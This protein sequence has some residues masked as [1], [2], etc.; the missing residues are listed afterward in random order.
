M[1]IIL[2]I[3]LILQ[4]Y[5][6]HFTEGILKMHK[7]VSFILSVSQRFFK[8]LAILMAS[9]CFAQVVQ[10]TEPV[11]PSEYDI[12]LEEAWITMP[13][14]VRL[15]VD[16]YMPVGGSTGE[17]YPVILQYDPYRKIES[18]D[19][20][21]SN[22]SYFV[23]RGYVIARV[24]IR[25]SGNSEGHLVPY[26]YSDQE[27]DDGEVI[28]DWLSK[29]NWSNGNV[30]MFG[31]SWSGFNSIQL[32]VRNPPALKAI[33]AIDSTEDLYQDD[34]HYMDGIMHVDIWEMLQELY[35]SMP[36]APDYI[37][38][39][40]YFQNRFDAKPWMLTWKRQQRDGPFWDRASARDKYDQIRIPTFHIGGWYDGY[41]DSVPRMLENVKAPV[42]AIVGAWN[43]AW[44]HDPIQLPGI[45]WRH[46]GVRWF[47]QWL[48]GKDTGIM[49]EP[50]LAVYVREWHGPGLTL[51]YAPGHWRWEKDWPIQDVEQLKL[52]PQ[53]NH[54]LSKQKPA[55]T[56]HRLKYVATSG[57]EASGPE[58]WWG[59]LANDQRPTDAFSLTYDTEPLAQDIEILG[60]PKALLRVEADT[61]RANWFVKLSDVAPDGAVTLITG[62]GFN[63]THRKSARKP[64]DIEP[65]VS[66]PL[67]IEMHF[68]SWV[69]PKGHRIRISISNAQW[70]MM[71]PTPYPMTTGLYLGGSIG[72]QI[73]LPVIPVRNTET[74]PPFLPPTNNAPKVKGY[75]SRQIGNSPG[76]GV[77]SSIKRNPQTGEAA[78]TVTGEGVSIYP[79]GE[80]RYQERTLFETSD[81]NPD[82]TSVSG[83]HEIEVTLK[84]RV[85]LWDAD[86]SFSSD[87]KNF[88]YRYKR[89]LKENDQLLREKEWTDVI[90]RDFQ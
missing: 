54:S 78:I 6:F 18:R 58:L 40:E 16:L 36:A 71:W 14:D 20:S 19:S 85:L 59:S 42:K 69:F 65:G 89:S 56:I 26:D 88:F 70:P 51:D 28:I 8:T 23:R 5:S 2:I 67:D 30:G 12:K 22:Y 46:E 83:H 39:K 34:V 25:G 49:D 37:I 82:K 60:L 9:V 44:P 35:N 77:M 29:Q 86:F 55:E 62:A 10:A 80:Q 90:P 41:R 4:V 57:V 52:F 21:M 64:E 33:I 73:I 48:K 17:K 63:G 38:D 53:D 68:T 7:N 84:G 45:E 79:W 31:V 87:E 74:A 66:F 24:D 76:Y 43:H 72:S 75:G 13:D 15:S 32:A 50:K 47:D 27:L 11:S 1:N 81:A 61:K 3:T